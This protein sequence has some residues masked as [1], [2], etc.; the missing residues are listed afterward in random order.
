MPTLKPHI[1]IL[2]AGFGGTYAAKG[3]APLVKR[4]EID[5]TIVNKT[6]YFLF[7]PLLHEVATGALPATSVAES[8]REI[9]RGSGIRMCQGS[10]DSIDTVERRVHIYGNEIRHTI[11]YDYLII[12]TGSVTEYYGIN[13]A[14]RF[15]LPL[16][17]LSDAAKIRDRVISAFE[18]AIF[19]D[20]PKERREALSF[21]VV[22]G[23]PTGV[24]VASELAEMVRGM[25]ARY[26]S[27]TDC[28]AGEAGRCSPEEATITLIHGGSEILPQLDSEL[29]IAASDRLKEAG[30]TLCL[31]KKVTAVGPHGVSV[32]ESGDLPDHSVS[33]PD[34]IIAASTVIWAAGVKPCV[35]EFK[36]D[37]PTLISGRLA[38]DEYLRLQGEERVFAL[39]DIAAFTLPTADHYQT[40][41]KL[42]PML[43]QTA[44]QEAGNAA[45][46]IVALIKQKKLKPF[47]YHPKGTLVSVG[48]WFAVGQIFSW[49]TS[50]KLTWWIWRT[51]YLF[52]FASWKKRIRIAFSWTLNTIYP[53]DITNMV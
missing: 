34:Q 46:N 15:C 52:K 22:G 11:P 12:A 50:G 30:V 4:G 1:L 6:N 47:R 21:A 26:Y 43:G 10:I 35:P 40:P 8:I 53:R 13:G 42:A 2:G 39:G 14:E 17:T 38:V 45:R 7:T 23:G 44:V 28:L 5:V 27:D 51:I 20:D 41:I 49:K 48:Q 32:S 29:R 31:G 33:Q 37:Q 3:L 18:K 16:K 9:F 24:E 19:I 25:I 36:D